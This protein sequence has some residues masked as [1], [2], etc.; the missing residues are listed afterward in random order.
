MYNGDMFIMSPKVWSSLSPANQ[1]AL[2]EAAKETLAYHRKLITD[3]E[4]GA[5]D[6][7]KK[8]GVKVNNV[9]QA[10]FVSLVGEVYKKNE[11]SVPKSLVE[12]IR[13]IK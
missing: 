9:N 11:G 5:L 10:P 4:K 2:E 7:I 13:K 12:E 1:K 8:A 6:I 3:E